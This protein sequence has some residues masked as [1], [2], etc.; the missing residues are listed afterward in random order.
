M[1]AL[2][3][4]TNNIEFKLQELKL[5]GGTKDYYGKISKIFLLRKYFKNIFIKEIFQNY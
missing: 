4:K 2:E 5:F 1:G 3:Q